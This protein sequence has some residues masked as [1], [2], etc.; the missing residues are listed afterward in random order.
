MFLLRLHVIRYGFIYSQ[1]IFAASR[2]PVSAPAGRRC[3]LAASSLYR[4]TAANESTLTLVGRAAGPQPAES[5]S[6]RSDR[7]CYNVMDDIIV[8]PPSVVGRPEIAVRHI[9]VRIYIYRGWGCKLERTSSSKLFW[10]ANK[11]LLC[12]RLSITHGAIYILERR[13][14]IHVFS[15]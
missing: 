3:R 8:E 14:K 13:D 7:G 9:I 11:D 12:N 15:M 4:L 10:G 1:H 5:W 2:L 6:C